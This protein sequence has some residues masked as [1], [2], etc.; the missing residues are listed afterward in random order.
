MQETIDFL[1]SH[2]KAEKGLPF[3]KQKW[4]AWQTLKSTVLAQQTN[5]SD[6]AAALDA[7]ITPMAISL[8][9]EHSWVS[10]LMEISKRLNSAKVPN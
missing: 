2:F 6:Y 9:T 8:G 5:N 10:G 3:G 7:I 4:D 1:E